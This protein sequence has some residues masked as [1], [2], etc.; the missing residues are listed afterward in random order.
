MRTLGIDL[1][2]TH[3][4]AAA[5]ASIVPLRGD[6]AKGN[7]LLPSIVA[8][9][10][11]GGV[12]V[13]QAARERRGNDPA[14]TIVSA[15]RVIGRSYSSY[16]VQ[17]YL[18]RSAVPVV[19]TSS[20]GTAFET[21]AGIVTPVDVA[22]HVL[23]ELAQAGQMDPSRLSA[24][25]SVPAA[26]AEP[27]RAATV[28]AVRAAGFAEARVVEEPVA[29]AIAYLARSSL[30]YAVVYDLG[31]GTFDVAIVDCSK[32]PFRVIAH[33]GDAYLGGDDVDLALAE[34][35]AD[36]VLRESGW[37]L[38]TDDEVWQRLL[39]EAERAKLR[40]AVEEHTTIDLA[41][42]DPAAPTQLTTLGI[43]RRV[44]RDR[45]EDL[46]RRTFLICDQV[47][48]DAGIRAREVDAVFLAGGSTLLPGLR[49][50]VREYFGKRARF[51]LDPMH[52]VAI[53]A[54]VAA[55]RPDL[56]ALLDPAYVR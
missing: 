38:S 2:T 18:E 43:D 16:S 50:D 7:S 13:G 25:V 35:V 15:K 21:R 54:S 47:L 42:V 31:G 48:C 46:I 23:R 20:G 22:T 33:G 36:R 19:R 44:L 52:V 6:S 17:R 12:L 10:P 56:S 27:E 51:D 40:L 32:Y 14:N 41:V 26:F 45:A 1:G 30:K 37:D 9:P 53:G 39:I 8:F 28:E 11:A 5:T 4:V 24:V 55:A 29:T 3:T 34:L 49:D